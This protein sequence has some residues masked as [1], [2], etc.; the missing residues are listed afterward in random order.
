[1]VFLNVHFVCLRLLNFLDY[2]DIVFV[3]VHT[4]SHIC[5]SQMGDRVGIRSG[6]NASYGA[7]EMDHNPVEVIIGAF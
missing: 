1:M 5:R 4:Y 3:S 7:T 2:F 6:H